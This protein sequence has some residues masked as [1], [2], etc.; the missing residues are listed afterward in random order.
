VAIPIV[1]A[2]VPVVG[3][4]HS[5]E[6]L[7]IA[8]EKTGSLA[9]NIQ[10]H[11]ADMRHFDLR[12]QF[13]LVYCP[14]RAFL[15]LSDLEDHIACLRA[16]HRHLWSG[17]RFALNFFVPSIPVIASR[18][19]ATPYWEFKKEFVDPRTGHPFAVSHALLDGP[20]RQR[21]TAH[22]RYE[23]VDERERVIC[24][25]HKTSTLC[26]IWPREFMHLLARCGFEVEALYGDCDHTPFGPH[27]EEQVWVA[28]RT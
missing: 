6:I 9:L 3:L 4:D 12:R 14:A 28:R 24:T 19:S 20:F 1:R 7:A 18:L 26:W 13:G 16:V 22:H 15:H 25:E 23:E 5:A 10:L 2:G 27:S 8:H 17:G 21:V 11:Q